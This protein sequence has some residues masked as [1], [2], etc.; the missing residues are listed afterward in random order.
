MDSN[1]TDVSINR[2]D[3]FTRKTIHDRLD[4]AG[5]D[6]I[7]DQFFDGITASGFHYYYKNEDADD[8]FRVSVEQANGDRIV[9]STTS[10]TRP[11]FADQMALI[12]RPDQMPGQDGPITENDPDFL[13]SL[14]TMETV[15]ATDENQAARAALGVI[16]D[17]LQNRPG[18]VECTVHERRDPGPDHSG[19]SP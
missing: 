10:Y 15:T 3:D 7:T 2:G 17:R 9:L 8:Y 12:G 14:E 19:P 4:E 6:R 13:V 18:S 5:Y 1:N 16:A 11:Q